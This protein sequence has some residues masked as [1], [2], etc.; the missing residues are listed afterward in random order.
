MDISEK[1]LGLTQNI[2]QTPISPCSLRLCGS[3]R[4]AAP[5]LRYSV[6][7]KECRDVALLRLYKGYA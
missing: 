5:R 1:E 7:P 6:S 2:S 3:L 4:Q